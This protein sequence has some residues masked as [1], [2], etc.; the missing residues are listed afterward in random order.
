M[1]IWIEMHD[2]LPDHI[3]TITTAA[4]LRVDKDALVGKLHRLWQWA[5]KSHRDGFIP[6]VET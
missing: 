3:K 6:L 4:A 2:D 5:L 1:P